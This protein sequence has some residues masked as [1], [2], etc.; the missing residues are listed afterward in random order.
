MN[1]NK[2]PLCYKNSTKRHLMH[3]KLKGNL[4]KEELDILYLEHNYPDLFTLDNLR[5]I[6]IN[7]KMSLPKIK[8]KYGVWYRD[9]LFMLDVYGIQKKKYVR[10]I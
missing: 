8:E 5:E 6:Y 4:T 7:Q 10:S 2:C 9:T 3:C 1:T